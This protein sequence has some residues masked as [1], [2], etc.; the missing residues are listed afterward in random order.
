MI[1]V[2]ERL[3][4]LVAEVDQLE[5]VVG[6]HVADAALREPRLAPLRDV[7][8]VEQDPGDLV[9]PHLAAA[10]HRAAGR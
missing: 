3:R 7:G 8:G 6:D 1:A 5:Q 10:D 9:V 4:R 2:P